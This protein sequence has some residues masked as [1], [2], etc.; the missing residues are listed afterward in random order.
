MSVSAISGTTLTV[1]RG[2]DGTSAATAA[3]GATVSISAT[4]VSVT[5]ATG[6]SVGS[7][8]EIDNEIM[9]VTAI[10]GTVLTVI[11]GAAGT[12]AATH[13]NGATVTVLLSSTVGSGTGIAAGD[14]V[15]IDSEILQ[16]ASVSGTTII[17]S[18]ADLGTA[19]AAHSSGAAVQD[20]QDWIYF[21]LTASGNA[22]GCTGACLY[23]YLVTTGTPPANS[24]T[25]L[26][27]LLAERAESSSITFPRSQAHHRS[28][29]PR[30]APQPAQA[31]RLQTVRAP[32]D[33]PFRH[34]SRIHKEIPAATVRKAQ[35]RKNKIPIVA[36][37]MGISLLAAQRSTSKNSI[38]EDALLSPSK[39]SIGEEVLYQGTSSLVPQTS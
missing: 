31:T 16:V 29:T 17:T 6:I 1:A 30:A 28:T 10:N 26:T 18:R 21:S 38:G 2:D 24:T 7:F 9:S 4:L 13:A 8:I 27:K 5:S 20:I 15:Q 39:N 33:A 11:R 12:T 19:I 36:N 22:T 25:G 35:N 32:T 23:N 3:S 14:Y 37:T 34:L